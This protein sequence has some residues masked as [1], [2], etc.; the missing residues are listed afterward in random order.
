MS[1]WKKMAEAF[2]RA[3]NSP[4]ATARGRSMVNR[5]ETVR[6]TPGDIAPL[7]GERP[8]DLSPV[9][10]AYLKGYDEGERIDNAVSGDLGEHS[11]DADRA[12]AYRDKVE[13]AYTDMRLRKDFD[14]AFEEA[15]AKRRDK[16]RDA[17]GDARDA[18]EAA[19]AGIDDVRKAAIE[20]LKSGQDI[21]DVIRILKGE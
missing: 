7:T 13:D 20:M 6:H 10:N 8:S 18:D 21:G 16:I 12:G 2:G 9:Q 1:T 3:V 4:T 19:D 11:Y 15:L 17:M 14:E 5:S